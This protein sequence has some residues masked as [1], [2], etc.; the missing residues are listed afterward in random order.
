MVVTFVGIT[1][2]V[3]AILRLA[4]GDPTQQKVDF[5]QQKQEDSSRA[6]RL[7]RFKRAH[8]LDRPIFMNLRPYTNYRPEM[9]FWMDFLTWH[10]PKRIEYLKTAEGSTRQRLRTYLGRIKFPAPDHALDGKP[11][12]IRLAAT[13]AIR[14]TLT[15][16][17]AD[18]QTW[19]VPIV[20]D[21]LKT[22]RQEF[23]SAEEHIPAFQNRLEDLRV[24]EE[25]MEKQNERKILEQHVKQLEK[26]TGTI[27]VP[28]SILSLDQTTTLQ[29]NLLIL[30]VWQEMLPRMNLEPSRETRVAAQRLEQTLVDLHD[31]LVS[32]Q[33]TEAEQVDARETARDQLSAFVKQH[34][35]LPFPDTPLTLNAEES[36]EYNRAVAGLYRYRIRRRLDLIVRFM[37]ILNG[38]AFGATF[39]VPDRTLSASKRD[40]L[41]KRAENVA[42]LWAEGW[43][44]DHREEYPD[45]SQERREELENILKELLRESDDFQR[46]RSIRVQIQQSDLP[47]MI[48]VLSNK[49]EPLEKR[50][51]ASQ[52]LIE[53]LDAPR[54]YRMSV[55]SPRND[56][57]NCL[58]LWERW[59]KQHQNDYRFNPAE[60]LWWTV[61][62]TQYSLYMYD[63]VQLDFGDTMSNP[64]EPVYDRL[65]RALWRTGPL[66]LLATMF[67]YL[68]AI[69]LG[70][71]C[72]VKQRQLTDRGISISLLVLWAIPG[73]AA[74]LILI[75]LFANP[76]DG[77][78]IQLFPSR[79]LARYDETLWH[80]FYAV[81]GGAGEAL[82][83]TGHLRAFWNGTVDY[84]YHA[85]LPMFSTSVFGMASLALYSRVSML[86]VIRKDYIRTARAKGLSEFMVI[87]KHVVRNG[88]NPII[89]LFANLLPRIVGGSLIIEIIF[90]IQGVGKMFFEA[91]LA[92][93]Y[94]VMM[95]FLLITA[96]L[97]MVG[98]LVSDLLYVLVNPRLDFEEVET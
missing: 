39:R 19:L 22:V 80:L 96:V 11:F 13:N 88:L 27:R 61:S 7:I 51:L 64:V 30:R 36:P 82:G 46:R 12:Q 72:A 35:T 58:T 9:N 93:D 75:F 31:R 78:I 77:G 43:W 71:I 50:A 18:R 40:E 52:V 86:E 97:V 73:Y 2:V 10:V 83:F 41:Q 29:A 44:P 95:C 60:K 63:L 56:V 66:M 38:D 90:E 59:W 25:D 1:I 8:H 26:H 62:R 57:Q 21:E 91:A 49:N 24:Q 94:N 98:I 54:H 17:L 37:N 4:P 28:A 89:T 42:F 74:A 47:H 45:V 84:L 55:D 68:M 34:G 33:L 48:S 3:F 6:Q 70:I 15:L 69:P 92:R 76:G 5:G 65:K 20:V 85:F 23:Q 87:G 79:G 16:N 14:E 67:T 53:Y 32:G 81:S